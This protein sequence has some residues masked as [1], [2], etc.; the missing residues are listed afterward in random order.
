MDY[1]VAVIGDYDSILG[2]NALGMELFAAEDAQQ[3][4]SHLDAAAAGGYAIVYITEQ[5]A[6]GIPE[7]IADYR[8]RKLPAI[9][10][11]PSIKGSTGI[12]MQQVKDS[13]KKAV[14]I[15]I[16]GFDE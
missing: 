13:V 8:S 3:A 2:F 16:L 15:D 11:I 4:A 7:K 6:E 10:P 5:L 14:G 12:G 9:V 1:K